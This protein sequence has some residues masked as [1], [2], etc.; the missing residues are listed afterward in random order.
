MYRVIAYD[1]NGNVLSDYRQP[2]GDPATAEQLATNAHDLDGVTL[3]KVFSI[4]DD[5]ATAEPVHTNP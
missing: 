1:V 4:D 2:D 3:V 5:P